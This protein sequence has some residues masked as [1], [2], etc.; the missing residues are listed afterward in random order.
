VWR[1]ALAERKLAPYGDD[2]ADTAYA[3]SGGP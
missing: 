1:I 2:D 3:G